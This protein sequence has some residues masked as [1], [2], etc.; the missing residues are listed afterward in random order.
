ITPRDIKPAHVMVRPAGI[1]KV[2]DFGLAKLTETPAL[3]VDSQ[4]ST[5]VKQSTEA[6][7]V[8]GTPG[9][10]SP[11]QA[12]GERV[13]ARTDIFSLGAMLYEMV[14]GRAPFAG[15]T[16][17]ETIAALL[18]DEPPP[19]TGAPPALARIVSRALH[20]DRT[21]RYH[22][23]GDLLD[24]LNHLKQELI[25]EKLAVMPSGKTSRRRTLPPEGA[26][27]S[28]ATNR[29]RLF[30]AL[31]GII[32]MTASA[33]AWFYFNRQPA[34]TE[35]DSI[36]LADFENKTG[37]AIFDGTLKQGLAIELQQSPFLN[38][39]PEARVQQALR[40][41]NRPAE[42][43]VTREVA[44]EICERQGIKAL[45][46]GSI[47]PLGGHY[48]ITLEAINAQNGEM[49]AHQQAQVESREQVLQVLSQAATRL[50]EKLGESLSSIQ[51]IQP[52]DQI[53]TSNLQA[54]KDATKGRELSSQGRFVE[55]IPF[56]KRAVEI[57]PQFSV[58]IIRLALQYNVTGQPDSAAKYAEQSF[59]LQDRVIE[60][61]KLDRTCWYHLLVTGNQN[62]GLEALTL[63]KAACDPRGR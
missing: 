2:L 13:D 5:V 29:R 48:V 14:A 60:E 42:S 41:M 30:V 25:V 9:Y 51:F 55:A 57:D 35:K 52:L 6:G 11:E 62:K 10:M 47:A 12:R 53:K 1:V 40:L 20:K 36:L 54:L 37:D 3:P 58:A 44:R 39:F 17:S 28:M 38:I 31:I 61:E 63:Q 23:A 46:A 24:D 33:A 49:L 22:S 26:T 18:R 50:R 45:I 56:L 59:L 8:M 7:M 27:T 43:R 21:E 16:T 4:L 15:A 32:L 19:L 34:L